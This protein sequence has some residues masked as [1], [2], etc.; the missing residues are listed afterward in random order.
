ML[1]FYATP[2]VYSINTIDGMYAKLLKLNPM[3]HIVEAYRS[4]FYYQNTP[5]LVNLGIIFVISL[6]LCILG[7]KLFKKLERRFA[8][9]I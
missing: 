7:Y 8:E 2:I 3:C 9:E 4:V 6:V 5:N 1:L